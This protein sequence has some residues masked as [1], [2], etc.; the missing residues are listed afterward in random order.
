MYVR[1]LDILFISDHVDLLTA[2][3]AYNFK[4]GQTHKAKFL[5]RSSN[6]DGHWVAPG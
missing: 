3:V 5:V 4:S 1:T 6:S 2:P